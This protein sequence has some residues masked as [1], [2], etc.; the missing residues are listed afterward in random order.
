MKRSGTLEVIL[1]GLTLCAVI[2]LSIA[3]TLL[4]TWVALEWLAFLCLLS[5]ALPKVTLITS[6]L[7]RTISQALW[8][9]SRHWLWILAIALNLIAVVE[10]LRLKP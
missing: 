8:P 6:F 5:F 7:D 3:H 1:L 4:V 10:T 2:S 9:E